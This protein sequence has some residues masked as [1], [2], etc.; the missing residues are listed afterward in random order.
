VEEAE[1]GATRPRGREETLEE[2]EEEEEEEEDAAV[3]VAVVRMLALAIELICAGLRSIDERPEEA[4][5]GGGNVCPGRRVAVVAV[6][7]GRGME[8]RMVEEEGTAAGVDEGV[9]ALW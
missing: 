2:E 3:A 8:E 9:A 5:P 4:E 7:G 6:L 1:A